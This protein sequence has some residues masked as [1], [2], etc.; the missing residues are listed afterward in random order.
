MLQGSRSVL[1]MRMGGNAHSA[2][3]GWQRGRATTGLVSRQ[4]SAVPMRAGDF[5]QEPDWAVVVRGDKNL[6]DNWRGKF[7]DSLSE[8]AELGANDWSMF[9]DDF[10]HYGD[11][12]KQLGQLLM[13]FGGLGLLYVVSLPVAASRDPPFVQRDMRAYPKETQE[14]IKMRHDPHLT[15][16]YNIARE[17]PEL[18]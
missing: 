2:A 7:P 10:P 18:A 8:S 4:S 16:K 15:P 5:V 11:G 17:T 1:P 6:Y 13:A 12:W 14:L 9:C 3:V